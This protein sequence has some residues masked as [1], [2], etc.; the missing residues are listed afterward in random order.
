MYTSVAHLPGKAVYV[1]AQELHCLASNIYHESRGEPVIG[2][3][4]VA[5][6]TVNRLKYP[7]YPKTVCGVVFQPKQFSWTHQ[8]QKRAVEAKEWLLAKR[9]AYEVL[10]NGAFYGFTATHYHAKSVRPKWKL[11]RITSIGNHVF[12][13]QK[14]V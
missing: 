6:V 3:L 4:A 12:Y 14:S 9:L 8:R 2:Q 5:R 7:E 1:D 11:E 10:A 13:E